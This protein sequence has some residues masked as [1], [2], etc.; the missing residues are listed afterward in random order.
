LLDIESFGTI[1]VSQRR[2][3]ARNTEDSVLSDPVNSMQSA[4]A[5]NVPGMTL[6]DLVLNSLQDDKAEDII[7]I[8]LAGKSTIA[9]YMVVASG[10]STRQVAAIADKLARRL[11]Q[12]MGLSVRQEGKATGDWVLLDAGDVIVHV[13]RPEVRDFYQLEKMWLP[14]PEASQA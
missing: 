1:P 14:M 5:K 13:F 9:D 4:S 3:A 10:R 7:T 8:D 12:T 2:S 11:K 6:L